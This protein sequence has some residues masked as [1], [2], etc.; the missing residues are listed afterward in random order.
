MLGRDPYWRLLRAPAFIV[1]MAFA[2]FDRARTQRGRRS[3]L[4]FAAIVAAL[5]V[6]PAASGILSNL[7]DP[8]PISAFQGKFYDSRTV[9][10]AMAVPLGAQ[11][12]AP[13]LGTVDWDGVS[14]PQLNGYVNAILARLLTAWHAPHPKA[15]VSVTANPGLQSDSNASGEIFIAR[16]W[17]EQSDSE[18]EVAAVIARQL[19]HILLDHF[20]GEKAAERRQ[21]SLARASAVAVT[22]LELSGKPAQ[23]G[24]HKDKIE[25]SLQEAMLVDLAMDSLSSMRTARSREEQ[26]EQADLLGT[27][28]L[29]RAQYNVHGMQDALQRQ[30]KY[31]RD[32]RA[33]IAGLTDIYTATLRAAMPD[34][35]KN[36]DASSAVA[37]ERLAVYGLL[38][39]INSTNDD[40]I[41]LERND[42][43]SRYIAREYGSNPGGPLRRASLDALRNNAAV[44]PVL[45]NHDA[46]SQALEQL[47]LANRAQAKPLA[48]RGVSGA[49]ASSPYALRVKAI[50]ETESGDSGAGLRSLQRAAQSPQASF[51]TLVMLAGSYSQAGSYDLAYQTLDAAGARLGSVEA[52]YPALIG[53]AYRQGNT[54]IADTVLRKCSLVDNRGIVAQCR[55]VA[56]VANCTGPALLCG[57]FDTQRNMFTD[58][59][60]YRTEHLVD[61]VYDPPD[62]NDCPVDPNRKGGAQ[63]H[64]CT[65]PHTGRDK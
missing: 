25:E 9:L 35:G 10:A 29:Y 63:D 23:D 31:D 51:A 57:P 37:R 11:T 58:L 47:A 26:D 49:T 59:S 40:A 60:G 20:T 27:D 28:L 64:P 34:D 62:T 13:R 53:L 3:R 17:I 15:W 2:S 42:Q 21:A 55:R 4:L 46:A 6:T 45:S 18:D 36:K 32:E 22:A 33:R 39:R 12:G 19:S 65:D 52:T 24:T 16:G 48:E 61:P 50:V 5:A 1:R 38:S 8:D 56:Q 7:V 30:T 44:K 41:V 14:S 43:L 54:S